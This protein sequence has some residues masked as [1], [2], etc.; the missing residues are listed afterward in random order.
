MMTS[1]TNHCNE[2]E[3]NGGGQ[4]TKMITILLDG[5]PLSMITT[6]D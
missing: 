2:I 3:D 5:L 1:T 6:I 4:L